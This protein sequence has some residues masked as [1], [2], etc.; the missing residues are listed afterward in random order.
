MFDCIFAVD[1]FSDSVGFTSPIDYGAKCKSLATEVSEI[2]I[3]VFNRCTSD[4]RT[5]EIVMPKR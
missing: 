2:E 3:P 5:F 4:D 1:N